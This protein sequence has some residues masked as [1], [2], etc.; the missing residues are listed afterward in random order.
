LSVERIIFCR[1]ILGS[2]SGKM[3]TI[4]LSSI[5]SHLSGLLDGESYEDS[6]VNGLQVESSQHWITKVAF[7]VDAG[8]RVIVQAIE[9]QAQL[10][11]VHHGM[12][13]T[14][15]GVTPLT[16]IMGRKVR[17]LIEGGCSLYASHLPLDGHSTLGNAAQLSIRIGLTAI[18]PFYRYKG[19]WIG[20]QGMFPEPVPLT[21]ITEQAR[22][23][24]GA[25]PV[26][27]LPFGK[28]SIQRVAVIT[29]AAAFAIPACAEAGFDLLITG[30]PKQEAYHLAEEHRLSV[31]F[32]G[33]Y[34]TETFGVRALQQSVGDTFGIATTFI[35]E[36]T[37]I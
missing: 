31:L 34:A 6:S 15:S 25:G 14:P 5:L 13:W 9:S 21:S 7:A 32:A 26:S 24:E 18:E 36:P 27:V 23:F 35:H 12:L 30:E 1:D 19:S 37:G 16:G 3:V 28:A 20:S 33:H 4:Q 8:E 2:G 11:I 29:G 22:T 10:L 17:R